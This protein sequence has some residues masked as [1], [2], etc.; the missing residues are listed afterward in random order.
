MVLV[1]TYR[2]C[3]F[4]ANIFVQ[5]RHISALL[6]S[7][8]TKLMSI[9]S[10]LMP[11]WTMCT[12]LTHANLSIFFDYQANLTYDCIYIVCENDRIWHLIIWK[13]LICHKTK[14]RKPFLI[15]ILFLLH[16][17]EKAFMLFN[18]FLYNVTWLTNG[19][20]KSAIN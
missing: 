20:K 8:Q 2:L 6:I 15:Y 9:S 3:S 12:F 1:N 11:T 19:N 14:E 13:P 17:V 7:M 16:N 4:E 10:I 5:T 18:T